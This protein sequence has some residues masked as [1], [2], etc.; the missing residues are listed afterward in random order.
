MQIEIDQNT[1]AD[2]LGLT[3]EAIERAKP[4]P[5]QD[6]LVLARDRLEAA[7]AK[8]FREIAAKLELEGNLI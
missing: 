3:D 1:V 7:V 6:T 8:R 2:L 4:G 5:F